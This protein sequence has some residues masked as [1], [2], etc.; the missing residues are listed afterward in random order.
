[1]GLVIVF[2]ICAILAYGAYDCDEKW[3]VYIY[4]EMDVYKYCYPGQKGFH[5]VILGCATFDNER[6]HSIILGNN[7]V[8]KSHTGDSILVH[9]IKHMSCLCNYHASPPELSRR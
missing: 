9:E 3:A 2:S 7:G 8:G 5:H 1:M 4:D 6:G